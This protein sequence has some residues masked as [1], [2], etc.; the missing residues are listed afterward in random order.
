MPELGLAGVTLVIDAPP[1]PVFEV[2]PPAGADVLVI[3]V[4]GPP[5]P[6]GAPGG[7]RY[8]YIQATP[9]AVWVINHNLGHHPLITLLDEAGVV[10]DSDV[11]HPSLNTTVVT[12]ATPTAGTAE[13]V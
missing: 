4:S 7:S 8:S 12:Y 6:A 11:E 9:A 1:G 10:I 3:P 13:L 5:G 2:A